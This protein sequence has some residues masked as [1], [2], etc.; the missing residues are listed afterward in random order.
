MKQISEPHIGE[1]SGEPKKNMKGYDPK[2][3][4]Y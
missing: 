1:E 4:Y 2:D 3:L